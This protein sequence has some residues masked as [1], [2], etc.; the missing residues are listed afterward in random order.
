MVLCKGMGYGP[1]HAGVSHWYS[2]K[3]R[4]TIFGVW[5]TAHCIGG[6]VAGYLAAGCASIGA[7]V[8]VLCAWAIALLCSI[9]L[10]W[11]MRDTPHRKDCHRLRN[12]KNDWPPRKEKH[13]EEPH[14]TGNFS[15]IHSAQQ[16]CS[17]CWPAQTSSSI[18]AHTRW[19]TGG[20]LISRKSKAPR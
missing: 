3:E 15:A 10:F 18:A 5:N 6:G 16:K 8:R 13:E 11:R 9:Y 2:V 7:G 14:L 17:G 12:S 20:R 4:G 1:L 19:W